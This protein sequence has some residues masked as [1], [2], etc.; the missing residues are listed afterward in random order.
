MDKEKAAP[1]AA[2]RAHR[3]GFVAGDDHPV[4]RRELIPPL[5]S[6]RGYIVSGFIA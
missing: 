6:V 4:V 3:S 1:T 5:E 2:L